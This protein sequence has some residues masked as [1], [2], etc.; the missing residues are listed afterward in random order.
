M[1]LDSR[2][3]AVYSINRKIK[4]KLID[5]FNMDLYRRFNI[6]VSDT[7]TLIG[8][9]DDY[10]YELIDRVYI[11]YGPKALRDEMRYILDYL[12]FLF[13]KL[14][15]NSLYDAHILIYHYFK[16]SYKHFSRR[17]VEDTQQLKFAF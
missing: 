9:Y 17:S 12:D 11:K 7:N 4:N 6:T 8:F 10:L 15:N 3:M 13:K 14:Q 1:K 5:E 2:N 16:R